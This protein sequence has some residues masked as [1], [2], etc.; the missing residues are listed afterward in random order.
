MQQETLNKFNDIYSSTYDSV[1]K[2]VILKCSKLED[3]EDIVQNVYL[4]VYKIIKNDEHLDL[5]VSYI[6]GIA[7]N[8]VKDYYRFS[9]KNKIL[10]FFSEKENVY[11]NIPS[12]IDIEKDFITKENIDLVWSY[13]K[14]KKI[15]IFK[16]FYLYY[17]HGCT[18]KEI[19]LELGISES[20]VK[21]HL[22][23]TI[24]EL[25]KIMVLGE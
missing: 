14:K 23:R 9:Y 12:F 17:Y 6:L 20:N 10:S 2:F 19:A 7:R 3:V 11:S 13:L 24:D 16:I 8:K 15:I 25:K 1:L 4:E 21:H 18:I 22:Y 5:N